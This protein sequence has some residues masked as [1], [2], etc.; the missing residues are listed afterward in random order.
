MDKQQE[1]IFE[2]EPITAI[3]QVES[4]SCADLHLKSQTELSPN[5]KPTLKLCPMDLVFKQPHLLRNCLRDLRSYITLSNTNSFYYNLVN[6]SKIKK[7]QILMKPKLKLLVQKNGELSPSHFLDFLIKDD[8]DFDDFVKNFDVNSSFGIEHI[9]FELYYENSSFV[10]N[11]TCLMKIN[12]YLNT[13]MNKFPL[14]IR[15]IVKENSVFRQ[16]G[17]K[18]KSTFLKIL[19]TIQ[20]QRLDILFQNEENVIRQVRK[21]IKS[22]KILKLN[23]PRL[24]KVKIFT[25]FYF[26]DSHQYETL[27]IVLQLLNFTKVTNRNFFNFQIKLSFFEGL[28]NIFLTSVIEHLTIIQNQ[29]ITFHYTTKT[30][31]ILININENTLFTYKNDKDEPEKPF[32]LFSSVRN[33]QCFHKVVHLKIN[34]TDDFQPKYQ[35]ESLITLLSGIDT[36]LESLKK[37]ELIDS[38]GFI[39]AMIGNERILKLLLLIGGN[40]LLQLTIS[41]CFVRMPNLIALIS[42]GYPEL[43]SLTIYSMDMNFK[44][45]N[46][47]YTAKDYFMPLVNLEHLEYPS[48]PFVNHQFPTKLRRLDYYVLSSK[49]KVHSNAI[50][51]GNNRLLRHQVELNQQQKYKSQNENFVLDNSISENFDVLLK[52]LE[53]AGISKTNWIKDH[54]Y[55]SKCLQQQDTYLQVTLPFRHIFIKRISNKLVKCSQLMTLSD[56]DMNIH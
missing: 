33:V 48:R 29:E 25:L 55:K 2:P 39:N 40:K 32:Y 11:K 31:T 18:S 35:W 16:K 6:Q 19:K 36:R 10:E 23:N 41:L 4:E 47:I 21:C 13:I 30:P 15:I 46:N 52:I 22:E 14:C 50:L 51:V 37:Y 34:F 26:F 5:L 1:S 42:Q 56:F 44:L 53:R 38:A 45:H 54:E 12:Y 27:K 20:L 49:I 9:N 8:K 17:D 24:R 43:K 7:L 3:I 28:K